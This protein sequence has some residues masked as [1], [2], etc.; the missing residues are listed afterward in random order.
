MCLL[1][2]G[3][4]V[5]VSFACGHGCCSIDTPYNNRTVLTANRDERAVV[6][7]KADAGNRPDVM[8]RAHAR[9]SLLGAGVADKSH[10]PSCVTIGQKRRRPRTVC[11]RHV[12]R[13]VTVEIA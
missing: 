12:N 6:G 1:R 8:E 4:F 5:R 11:G 3:V 10:G 2:Q 7:S 9:T 13:T